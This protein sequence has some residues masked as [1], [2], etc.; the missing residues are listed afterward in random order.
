MP[1]L[2]QPIILNHVIKSQSNKQ[3]FWHLKKTNLCTFVR[4]PN[5]SNTKMESWCQ[6]FQ[7]D[8]IQGKLMY[9]ILHREPC[10][11]SSDIKGLQ[12]PVQQMCNTVWSRIEFATVD[13]L[14]PSFWRLA[15]MQS[16]TQTHTRRHTPSSPKHLNRGKHSLNRRAKHTD[17]AD[18]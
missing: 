7:H 8:S 2:Y 15:Y 10:T 11:S 9:V 1:T 3:S 12:S 16:L 4:H 18:I 17:T 13:S 14:L 5:T 6:G